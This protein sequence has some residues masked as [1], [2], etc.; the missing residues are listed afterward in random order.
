MILFL[1]ITKRKEIGG[2]VKNKYFKSFGFSLHYMYQIF[3]LY[4][5]KQQLLKVIFFTKRITIL[6]H[7]LL[8]T[9]WNVCIM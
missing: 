4:E 9:S 5:I 1:T 6:L 8:G 7:P 2:G 3:G